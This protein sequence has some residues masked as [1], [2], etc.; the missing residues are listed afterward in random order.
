MTQTWFSMNTASSPDGSS[1][2]QASGGDMAASCTPVSISQ[3]PKGAEPGA[4]SGLA[5]TSH[6][7]GWDL[8]F[9]HASLAAPKTPCPS[10]S[11]LSVTRINHQTAQGQA[12][13]LGER[14]P[15]MWIKGSSGHCA[16][17]SVDPAGPGAPRLHL[18]C[19]LQSPVPS[20]EERP[21]NCTHGGMNV[22]AS[23]QTQSLWDAISR[24]HC[25]GPP[26]PYLSLS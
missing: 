3:V 12:P 2:R 5:V 26:R 17:A 20:T 4:A 7:A 16:E 8:H 24:T 18:S 13:S 25:G 21:Q 6:P 22:L 11:V 19:L 23:A 14:W 1:L 10:S 9:I 15:A